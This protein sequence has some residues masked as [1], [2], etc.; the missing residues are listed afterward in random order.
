MRIIVSSLPSSRYLAKQ[1]L[2]LPKQS[3]LR[4]SFLNLPS[5]ILICRLFAVVISVITFYNY[6]RRSCKLKLLSFNSVRRTRCES[7]IIYSS[8]RSKTS[9]LS[10][11]Q[12]ETRTRVPGTHNLQGVS[13]RKQIPPKNAPYKK[14][15]T[16]K[17]CSGWV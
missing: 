14:G 2:R 12:A 4:S 16:K 9:L 11:M 8:K 15:V 10:E 3:T 5:E 13:I 7:V 17:T 1:V 6:N